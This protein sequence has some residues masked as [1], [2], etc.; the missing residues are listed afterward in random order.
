MQVLWLV[1]AF[2]FVFAAAVLWWLGNYDVAFVL[3]TLG[4]CAWFLNMRV[5]LKRITVVE[6]IQ[7]N[8][9]EENDEI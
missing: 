5:K 6:Q 3:A 9:G 2:A 1:V 7:E 4:V 8:E